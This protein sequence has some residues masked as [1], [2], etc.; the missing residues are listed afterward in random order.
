MN[1]KNY[2]L[3]IVFVFACCLNIQK[4]KAQVIDDVNGKTYYYYDST[5]Q[6]K[7]KEIFHHI[8]EFQMTFDNNGNSKDTVLF[9]KNGPYTK[10]FQTGQLECSGGFIRD[11]KNGTWKYYN[12]KGELIRTEEWTNGKLIKTTKH[13]SS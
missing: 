7:V 2:L 6:K 1:K 5:S 9:I 12:V 8:Q 10:Y 13:K 4:V 3:F 11:Q